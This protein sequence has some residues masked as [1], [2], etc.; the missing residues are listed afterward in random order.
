M[1]VFL[2]ELGPHSVFEAYH[3]LTGVDM[4][5]KKRANRQSQTQPA[6]EPKI[7]KELRLLA[8]SCLPAPS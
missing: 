8:A 6:V 3:D 7:P 1:P 4:Q 2:R 5:R